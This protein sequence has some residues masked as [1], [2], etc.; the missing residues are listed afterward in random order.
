M[1]CSAVKSGLCSVGIDVIDIGIVTT[2]AVGVMLRELNCAGGV[3]I[4]A[5]HNP[6]EYNGMKLLLDN[7]MA[8]PAQSAE[9]IKLYYFGKSFDFVSS[10]DCGKIHFDGRASEIHKL[11]S[12][13]GTALQAVAAK[14]NIAT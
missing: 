4:T 5:S 11:F 7:G 2:P 14:D 9:K 1:L 3:V 6:I 8:P 10:V 12:V 13:P